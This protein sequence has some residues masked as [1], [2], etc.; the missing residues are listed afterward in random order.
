MISL[1]FED[2]VVFLS[3]FFFFVFYFLRSFPI[4]SIH[5]IFLYEFDVIFL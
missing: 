5:Y 1:G 3:A 2:F 4:E